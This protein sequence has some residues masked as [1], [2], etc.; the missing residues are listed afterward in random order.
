MITDLI[1]SA[2]MAVVSFLLNLLPDIQMPGWIADI[3]GYAASVFAFADSIGV[4]IPWG[5]VM[6]VVASVF[7]CAGVGFTIKVVRMVISHVTGGGGSAA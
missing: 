2:F 7:A 5:V 4:W 6:T 1:I 3:S